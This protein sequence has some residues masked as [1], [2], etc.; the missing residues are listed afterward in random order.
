MA[1]ATGVGLAAGRYGILWYGSPYVA[2]VAVIANRLG[3][4]AAL[5]AAAM[6]IAAL[7][8]LFMDA[9]YTWPTRC[10][11]YLSIIAVAVFVARPRPPATTTVYD[12]GPDLPFTGRNGGSSAEE[13]QQGDR[14]LHSAGWVYWDVRPSGKWAEDCRVGSEYCRIWINRALHA[15]RV[16][17][18]SWIVHDMVRAGRWSGVEAGFTSALE[19]LALRPTPRAPGSAE[20]PPQS[21]G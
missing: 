17:L 13:N 12:R 1:A 3:L 8:F 2:I 21:S 7:H 19:K 20:P 9:D 14:S 5:L 16:P 11:A 18:L 4:R 15:E 6:G 10:V